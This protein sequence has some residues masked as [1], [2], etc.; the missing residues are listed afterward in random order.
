MATYNNT[1][2]INDDDDDGDNDNNNPYVTS[3]TNQDFY[4]LAGWME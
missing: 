1:S 4:I 2:Y 3:L